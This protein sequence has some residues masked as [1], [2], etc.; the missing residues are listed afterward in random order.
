M[1][2]E[3]IAINLFLG[4]FQLWHVGKWMNQKDMMKWEKC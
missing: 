2:Y 4:H 3:N 1:A